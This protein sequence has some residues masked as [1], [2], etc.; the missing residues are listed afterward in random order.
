MTQFQIVPIKKV[1]PNRLNPRMDFRK[2]GLDELAASISRVGLLERVLLR[3]RRGAFEVVV[4]ER[5]NRAALQAGLDEMPALVENDTDQQVA[6]SNLT[7]NV[8]R[9]DL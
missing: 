9:E 3:S 8:Q 2:E 1:R 7:E 6:E 5:R 4:D